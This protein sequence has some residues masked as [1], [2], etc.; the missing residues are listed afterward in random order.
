MF[1]SVHTHICSHTHTHT[2]THT[3]HRVHTE[4][5]DNFQGSAFL[6]HVSCQA[7]QQLALPDKPSHW[8]KT[9]VIV[10]PLPGFYEGI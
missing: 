7:L 10:Q 3:H 5:E 2:H 9:N 1:L 8:P 4:V 6:C